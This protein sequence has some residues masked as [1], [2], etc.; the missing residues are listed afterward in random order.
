MGSNWYEKGIDNFVVLSGGLLALARAHPDLIDGD[1]PMHLLTPAVSR[2]MRAG[3]R[4]PASAVGVA[5]GTGGGGKGSGGGGEQNRNANTRSPAPTRPA[6]AGMA[7]ATSASRSVPRPVQWN[8]LRASQGLAFGEG[9]FGYTR[10][11][12]SGASF[13]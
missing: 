11:F 3:T 1:L 8:S 13:R 10:S 5:R 7:S 9:S 12:E 6:T 2:P 4:R